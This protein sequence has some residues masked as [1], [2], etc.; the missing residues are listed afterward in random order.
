MVYTDFLV[1]KYFD[2]EI[3]HLFG[4]NGFESISNKLAALIQ[5]KCLL[6]EIESVKNDI[7]LLR[8]EQ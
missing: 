8:K 2:K 1:E 6:N 4:F 3:I 5:P 7:E